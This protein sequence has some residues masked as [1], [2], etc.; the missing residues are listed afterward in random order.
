MSQANLTDVLAGL[1]LAIAGAIFVHQAL[2]LPFGTMDNI[3]PAV[4]PFFTGGL[5]I[6]LGIAILV[7]GFFTS[8]DI[9]T[10]EWRAAFFVAA[11]ILSFILTIERFGLIPSVT[12]AS[13]L[14]SLSSKSSSLLGS[15][16]FS[17]ALGIGA[18]AVFIL[19]LNLPIAAYR[20]W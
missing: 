14:A 18:W 9:P 6:L 10:M 8:E 17:I 12:I 16:L 15:L 19:G 4:F 1:C 13:T 2:N 3:G 5:I 11:S 20:M 7:T